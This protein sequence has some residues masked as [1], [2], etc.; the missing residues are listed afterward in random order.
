MD[1]KTKIHTI[2]SI[3]LVTLIAVLAYWVQLPA[4]DLKAQVIDTDTVLIRIQ[5]FAF[6]PDIVRIEPDT[7]ISWLHDESEGNA[8]VQHTVTSYDPEDTSKSGEEFESD[9]MSLGDT[10]SNTFDEEGVYYYN[11]SFYP[12]MTGKVCVGEVSEILDEECAIEV[13]E[14]EGGLTE[15]ETLDEEP[16]EEEE[17]EEAVAEEEGD[18]AVVEEEGEEEEDLSPAADEEFEEE[19]EEEE[20]PTYIPPTS[21]VSESSMFD[22]NGVALTSTTA[23]AQKSDSELADSGPEVVIYFLPALIGGYG[24]YRRKKSLNA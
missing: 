8:D 15:E 24:I 21:T 7:T 17:E 22:E 13:T 12:F 3:V 9:V 10:F 14:V 6:D 23:A 20:V 1:T 2:I 19:E 5:D 18:E 4:E 11:S 16:A